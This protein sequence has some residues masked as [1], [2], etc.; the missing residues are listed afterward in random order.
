MQHENIIELIPLYL[1]DRLS[2][3]ERKSVHQALRGD[4]FLL[5]EFTFLNLVKES[6]KGENLKSPG[7][8]GWTKLKRKIKAQEKKTNSKE[9]DQSDSNHNIWWKKFAIAASFVFLLQTGYMVQQFSSPPE[10]F[11]PLSSGALKNTV[12]IQFNGSASERDL[13]RLLF[14]LRGTIV[15][16]PSAVG[17][18]HVHFENMT[19]AIVSLN[20]SGIVEYAEAAQQ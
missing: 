4:Y 14:E 13:R 6:I 2:D 19:S 12:K 9:S 10:N 1:N 3:S 18:Y 16:G 20:K 11:Q 17:I 5:Q 7:T 15:K 8:L